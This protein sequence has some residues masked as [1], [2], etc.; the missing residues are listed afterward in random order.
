M[1]RHIVSWNYNPDLSPEKRQ[2]VGQLLLER[3][4]ALPALIPCLQKL[5]FFPQAG[6]QSNCDLILYTEIDTQENLVTYR[7][8][9]EHQKV[10]QIIKEHCCD[11][12][13][14]DLI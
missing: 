5:E 14:T 6:G 1:V 3:F 13:C 9:P 12:R 7:D 10:V 2:E 8:H 11:R 4:N